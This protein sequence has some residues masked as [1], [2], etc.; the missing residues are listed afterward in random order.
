MSLKK[1]VLKRYFPITTK[2][3]DLTEQMMKKLCQDHF[4]AISQAEA[5][6]VIN[7][8]GYIGTLVKIEIGYALGKGKPVYFSHK[9]GSID[10]DSLS[11][12]FIDLDSI[13]DF[14]YL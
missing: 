2:K 9:T 7:P 8:G 6:Y 12:G 13:N 10:L 5:L 3:I 1:L 4:S 14:L 11:N